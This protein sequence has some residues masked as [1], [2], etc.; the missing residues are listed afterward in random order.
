[1]RRTPRA[2]IQRS[3]SSSSLDQ[4]ERAGD[5]RPDLGPE[6]PGTVPPRAPE[7]VRFAER[8]EAM[9]RELAK[10]VRF[11]EGDPAFQHALKTAGR[12]PAGTSPIFRN[13]RPPTLS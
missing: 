5:R 11:A 12:T 9:N 8:G 1:M 10:V 6:P 13:A 2:K 7:P 4:R 3:S